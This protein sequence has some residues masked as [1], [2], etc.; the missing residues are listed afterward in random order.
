MQKIFFIG[1]LVGAGGGFIL[2]I[3]ILDKFYKELM[4][5]T[6][7]EIHCNY[8]KCLKYLKERNY[9]DNKF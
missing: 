4:E 9:S 6:I 7:D 3:F 5:K 8:K 1:M 2:S